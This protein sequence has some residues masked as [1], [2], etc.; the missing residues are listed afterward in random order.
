MTTRRARHRSA[1]PALSVLLI[2][3]LAIAVA[4]PAQA[5]AYRFWTYWQAGAG[6][7]DW[8]YATQGPATAVP[9]DGAVEGWSFAISSD[10]GAR[11][12]APGIAP[13]F[14]TVC[15][16][17]K[18]TEGTKRIA[19]VIDPG[20]AG[21]SPEGE[22]PFDRRAE[23]IVIE[24][25][26]TGYDVLRSVVEVR[27]E[28]GLVCGLGGYPARECAP[29]LDD[30]EVVL[31]DAEVAAFSTAAHGSSDPESTPDA[32]D[33]SASITADSG[34]SGGSPVATIA[35]VALLVAAGGSVLLWRRR[36][37]S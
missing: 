21:I 7:T 17:V 18:A 22:A 27:T 24:Q 37:P 6:E 20:A 3:A 34:E 35:V 23:C 26:A 33:V 36:R 8:T 14:A 16:D 31:D 12:A 25:E 13:D 10:A 15:G 2:G 32:D 28:N 5:S 29:I 11:E 30:A 9:A 1:G 4:A 19:L